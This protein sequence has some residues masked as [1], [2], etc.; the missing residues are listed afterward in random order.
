MTRKATQAITQEE[1]SLALTRFLKEGGMI[2]KL[3]AQNFRVSGMVGGE[4]YQAFETLNDLPNLAGV[5]EQV[6]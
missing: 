3:P 4:K 6:A 2:R 1:V 5:T